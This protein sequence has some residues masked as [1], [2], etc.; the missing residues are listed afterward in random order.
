MNLIIDPLGLCSE[1][2]DEQML[3]DDQLAARVITIF[4]PPGCPVPSSGL[5]CRAV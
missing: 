3:G 4:C 2:G 1:P 5:I